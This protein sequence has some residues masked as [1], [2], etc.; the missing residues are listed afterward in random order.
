VCDIETNARAGL[1]SEFGVIGTIDERAAVIIESH[2]A[3]AA[4]QVW[5]HHAEQTRR[6]LDVVPKIG[7]DRARFVM[8]SVA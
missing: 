1:I 7:E 8:I 4:A 3:H 5:M 2:G 6:R